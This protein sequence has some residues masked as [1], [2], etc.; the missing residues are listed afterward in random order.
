MASEARGIAAKDRDA[1]TY[2]DLVVDDVGQGQPVEDL[3]K[4]L[5]ELGVVL[6]LD[7]ALKAVH[8]V[9]VDRLVVAA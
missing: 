5:G 3:G 8:L 4:D 2:K 1:R 6:C 9:H 7:L